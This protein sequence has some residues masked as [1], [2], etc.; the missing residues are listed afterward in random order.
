MYRGFALAILLTALKMN[1]AKR[2]LI[3]ICHPAHAHFFRYPIEELLAR[4]HQV[5]VTSRRKEMA[6]ELLTAMG[7][8]HQTISSQSRGALGL[9]SELLLRNYRLLKVAR[10]FK[11]DVLTA[12]GGTFAAHVSA[13]IRRPSVVFYDTE[14]ARLQNAITYPLA[15]RVIVPNCYQAW[16]PEG[17]N[18]R[19]AG[20][21][22]LSYLHPLR[23]QPS[24]EIALAN[25]LDP[26]RPSYLLRLVS[27]NANHDI[28]EH[29]LHLGRV[30]ELAARFARSGRVIIS[31][32][33]E[34]PADLQALRY[35]GDPAMIHHLMAFCAGF[36]GESATMASECAVLG[37]P[38]VYAALTG[39][40]YTDEQETR[41]G[42]VRNV[43]RIESDE[44]WS[45]AEWLLA[46]Q[47]AENAQARARLLTDCIDVAGFATDRILHYAAAG[48]H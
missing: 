17:R 35:R 33:A 46:R 13:L 40:G 47:P 28:G 5:M 9:A 22:E 19:Y 36:F 7:V 31:S 15:T 42:L 41:Y 45:A 1:P 12:I 44:V 34:L 32:E 21:H 14:N 37:V 48:R 3:D 26:E 4:G 8:Q 6:T 38:A 24:R 2:I 39:R 16:L 18:E 29:G 20:Y 30:R 10:A 23:W 43:R 25:G 27:W 11:P